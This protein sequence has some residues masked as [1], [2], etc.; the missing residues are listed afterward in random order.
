M[1]VPAL[2]EAGDFQPMSTGLPF[3]PK[4]L[5]LESPDA[6]PGSADI[7][8]STRFTQRTVAGLNRANALLFGIL[9]DQDAP[10]LSNKCKIG[11]TK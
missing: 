8:P 10:P 7:T 5:E 2:V 3:P 11:N 1:S 9:C 4:A 6:L